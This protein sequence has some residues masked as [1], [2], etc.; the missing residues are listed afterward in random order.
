MSIF[1]KLFKKSTKTEP[2][3]PSKEEQPKYMPDK[4]L[5]IDE[6]F[7]HYFTHHGG[8]FLYA[9][10]ENDIQEHFEDI[11]VEHDYFETKV[12]C[13]DHNLRDRFNGNNLDYSDFNNEGSFYLT[14]CEYLIADSGAILFSS[15]QLKEQ[16]LALYPDTLVILAKTSQIVETISEGMRGIK[17]C[18]GSNLPTNITTLNNYK[19]PQLQ[20]KTDLLNYGTIN[21]RVYLI[22]LEDL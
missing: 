19:E 4:K 22:L 15:N 5:P 6:R 13:N 20:D 9:I 7:I 14:T 17:H 12:V 21:K 8:R 11:L 16:K 1:K 3:D 2:S 18:C 10:D